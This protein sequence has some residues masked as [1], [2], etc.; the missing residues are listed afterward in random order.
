MM[1]INSTGGQPDCR[2]VDLTLVSA[3]TRLDTSSPCTE[4]RKN[5]AERA[6]GEVNTLRNEY[7]PFEQVKSIGEEHPANEFCDRFTP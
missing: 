4:R 5:R 7:Y 3:V 6:G 2:R 1:L